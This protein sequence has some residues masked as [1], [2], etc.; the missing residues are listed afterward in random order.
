MPMVTIVEVRTPV[1]NPEP[2]HAEVETDL[3]FV[4]SSRASAL[5]F[6]AGHSEYRRDE[7]PWCWYVYDVV[8]D[9]PKSIPHDAVVIGR[10]GKSYGS[11]RD[12]WDGCPVL[13]TPAGPR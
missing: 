11:Q 8:L 4:G 9:D 5:A 10:D 1:L 3:A 7:Y 2:Y 12:A 6:V 13:Q